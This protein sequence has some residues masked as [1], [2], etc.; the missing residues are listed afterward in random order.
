VVI[1]ADRRFQRL[2][3]PHPSLAA[4]VVHLDQIER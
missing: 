2:V 4:R 1:T 3:E